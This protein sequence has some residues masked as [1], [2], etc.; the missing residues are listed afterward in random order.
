MFQKKILSSYVKKM[1]KKK[2]KTVNESCLN[3]TKLHKVE[4]LSVFCR[5]KMN[6][7]TYPYYLEQ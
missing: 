7:L 3:L 5:M 4:T 6:H 1:F 2:K